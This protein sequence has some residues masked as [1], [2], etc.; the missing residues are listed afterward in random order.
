MDTWCQIALVICLLAIAFGLLC[1]AGAISEV[2][3]EVHMKQPDE[4]I[5]ESEKWKYG[6]G[7]E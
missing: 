4:A 6:R 2:H 3:L 1:I 7:D 5:D